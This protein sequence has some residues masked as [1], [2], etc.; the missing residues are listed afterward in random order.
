M[1]NAVVTVNDIFVG[2]KDDVDLL[3]AL[4]EV[5]LVLKGNGLK[6]KRN[7]LYFGKIKFGTWVTK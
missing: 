5:F 2:V 3:E 7:C 6:L 4:P 1:K